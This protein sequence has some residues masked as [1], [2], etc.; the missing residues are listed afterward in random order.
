MARSYL[1]AAALMAAAIEPPRGRAPY[2][3]G[4]PNDYASAP[5]WLPPRARAK[6]KKVRGPKTQ[7]K[8]FKPRNRRRP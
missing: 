4:F 2:G 8:T 7:K 3:M 1:L 6:P 5:P